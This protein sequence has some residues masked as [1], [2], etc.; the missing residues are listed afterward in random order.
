MVGSYARPAWVWT[1]LEAA[2]RGELGPADLEE[3][4]NDA[5]DMALRDQEEAGVDVISDGEMR[6][7]GFF[8]RSIIL[9]LIRSWARCRD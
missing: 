6:R 1:A 5:V 3:V 8:T 2:G 9:R 7:A 4:Q